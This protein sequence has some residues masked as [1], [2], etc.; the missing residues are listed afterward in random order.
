MEILLSCYKMAKLIFAT[1]APARADS[2]VA[3]APKPLALISRSD[4][5]SRSFI[6]AI[7]IQVEKKLLCGE[8]ARIP[9]AA[10]RLSRP[11]SGLA[12][13]PGA[14]QSHIYGA[15]AQ[16]VAQSNDCCCVTL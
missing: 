16:I 14:S 6:L 9:A 13:L 12:R 11:V 2:E 4:K 7:N 15:A 1:C 5:L 3:S 8:A 10:G